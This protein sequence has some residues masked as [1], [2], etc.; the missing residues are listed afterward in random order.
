[1]RKEEYDYER[2][3][4]ETRAPSFKIY[5][6]SQIYASVLEDVLSVEIWKVFVSLAVAR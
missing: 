3:S 6:T 2:I 5:V 1:M 4:V